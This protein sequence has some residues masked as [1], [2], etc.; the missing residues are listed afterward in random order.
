[1]FTHGSFAVAVVGSLI[2]DETSEFLLPVENRQACHR[3]Y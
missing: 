3:G 1:M 2:W